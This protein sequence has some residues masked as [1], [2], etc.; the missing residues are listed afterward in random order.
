MVEK[1]VRIASLCVVLAGAETLHGI[2]RAIVLVP[3]MGKNNALKVSIVSGSALAFAVCFFLVPGIGIKEPVAL[4]ATGLVLA[5]FMASFDIILA[6]KL[7]K[8]PWA[9]IWRDFDPRTGNYLSFGL[10]FLIFIPYAVMLL[11]QGYF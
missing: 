6:R 3:S 4:L 11:Q 7:L 1:I 2:F 5:L 9:M 10:F 8:L